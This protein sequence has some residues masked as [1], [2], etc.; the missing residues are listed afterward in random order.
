MKFL[1]ILAVLAVTLF[2]SAA[3]L[4]TNEITL[5]KRTVK[6][7][8]SP[9]LVSDLRRLVVELSDTQRSLLT[10]SVHYYRVGKHI[11]VLHN[12]IRALD[13]K[14]VNQENSSSAR[15]SSNNSASKN[16]EVCPEK[17]VGKD[18]HYGLPLYRKGFEL[19][20]CT[21]FVPINKLV[22]IL[23]GLPEELSPSEQH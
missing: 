17:F 20:N 21:E 3:V 6:Y 10:S 12:I 1:W 23:V 13:G 11:N 2:I 8:D 18:L 5:F 7:K 16:L 14:T 9:D 4:Y 15:N 19:V 22:T